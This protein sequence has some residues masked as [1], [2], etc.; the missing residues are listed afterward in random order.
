MFGQHDPA[1][2]AFA[3]NLPPPSE[4]KSEQA[5]LAFGRDAPLHEIMETT[6]A[7][8]RLK[9]DPVPRELLVQLVESATWGPSAANA[10]SYSWVVVTDRATIERLVPVWTT[11]VQFYLETIATIPAETMDV[12]QAERMYRALRYQTERFAEIPALIV[13]CYDLSWQRQALRH[14]WLQVARATMKHGPGPAARLT[15]G[16]RRSAQMAEA[17]SVYPGVQNLLLTARA[18]G[19][20]ANITTLHLLLEH[21]F[22]KILG[23]PSST[24]TF[25]LIPVGWPLGKFGPVR[26]RPAGEAIYWDLGGPDATR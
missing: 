7:M 9:P 23:I 3:M 13:P 25:A 12:A 15:R 17:A 26:R 21:Q 16:S 2:L 22:M 4:A 1:R 6:R 20:G 5:E 11:A 18:L 24:R 14:R 19:L 8:R 10:Q